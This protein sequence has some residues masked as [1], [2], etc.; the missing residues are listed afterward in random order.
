MSGVTIV[1]V[2]LEQLETITDLFNAYRIWYRQQDDRAAVRA[3]LHE[4]LAQRQSV[5]FLALLE[6]APAAFAQLYPIYSSATLNRGW[7]LNDLFVMPHAR[8]QG[9]AVALLR[10]VEQ[11]GRNTG[12]RYLRLSTEITNT[13][14]QEI[15]VSHGWQR[16]EQFYYYVRWLT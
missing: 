16:D 13:N 3:F 1:Q 8:F 7:L 10:H 2:A 15:Y 5:I 4:R 12:A 14:A 9:V 6:E 11:F